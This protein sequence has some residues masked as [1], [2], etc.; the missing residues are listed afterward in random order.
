[1]VSL[2]YHPAHDSYHASF[3]AMQLLVMSGS[4]SYPLDAFRILDFYLLFPFLLKSINRP[5]ESISLFNSLGLGKL[6]EPYQRLPSPRTAFLQI[7]GIQTTAYRHLAAASIL[8]LEEF[9]AGRVQL[10]Q[11][12]IGDP[13][14]SAVAAQNERDKSVLKYLIDVLGELPV[15]GPGGLKART[16]LLEFRYDR[17]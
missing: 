2:A 3:R 16:N 5:Q 4:K 10:F 1:M 8:N 9:Q 14:R 17:A 12:E 13:L 6:K 15:H 7:E 11:P